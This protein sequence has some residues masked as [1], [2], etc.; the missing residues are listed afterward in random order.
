MDPAR[1]P[2]D[3][4]QIRE[5]VGP[6]TAAS[7]GPRRR[8]RGHRLRPGR[9][10]GGLLRRGRV[11]GRQRPARRRGAGQPRLRQPVAVA[12]LIPG[13][14]C[15]TWAP[16]AA[17]TCC[18]RPAGSARPEGVRPGHDRGDAGPGPGQRA[19]GRRGERGVPPRPDR[20][21]PAAGQLG[22]RDH[23]Q[24]RDQLVDRPARRVRRVLPC[25]AAGGRLGVSD[26]LADDDLTPAQRIQR[27]GQVGC[28]AGRP[29]SPSTA[30]A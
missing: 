12:D 19:R 1:Q 30:T 15:W 7:P 5:A 28:I 23:L 22:R 14:R 9:V 2:A 29:P 10:L 13:R 20:G 26:I 3:R 11:P 4:D 21:D 8:A 16:G 24:L 25:P 6:G 17:S 27:S 18:C